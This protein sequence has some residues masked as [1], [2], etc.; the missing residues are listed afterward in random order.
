MPPNDIRDS[1]WL[2]YRSASQQMPSSYHSPVAVQKHHL[3]WKS[4][5]PSKFPSR[6]QSLPRKRSLVTL[7]PQCYSTGTNILR[8]GRA[9]RALLCNYRSSTVGK[10]IQVLVRLRLETFVLISFDS[11]W[12]SM[13]WEQRANHM[14]SANGA[15]VATAVDAYESHENPSE[16]NFLRQVIGLSG[17]PITVDI[18][19]QKAEPNRKKFVQ[20]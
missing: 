10:I 2:H 15:S 5:K 16:R 14:L 20:E 13:P 17:V 11:F 19:G 12:K 1:K 8:Q 9:A 7:I 18:W 4:A 6:Q 3:L